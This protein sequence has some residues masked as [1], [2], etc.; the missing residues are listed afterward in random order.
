MKDGSAPW[1]LCG[2]RVRVPPW[3]LHA[4]PSSLGHER[5]GDWPIRSCPTW[6][7]EGRPR[8]HA[9]R[10]E[11]ESRC[12]VV[13]HT[14]ELDNDNGKV[15][16]VPIGRRLVGE[17]RNSMI[18][19]SDEGGDG[20]PEQALCPEPTRELVP[21]LPRR[22]RS[23]MYATPHRVT[24]E[25]SGLAG[26]ATRL[27]GHISE[28]EVGRLEL[29]GVGAGSSS[30]DGGDNITPPERRARTLG[31]LRRGGKDRHESSS[32]GSP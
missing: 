24:R 11:S 21:P 1:K 27:V 4:G 8:E 25:A 30:H 3:Q 18:S 7:V 19:R 12:S 6:G 29:G 13:I 20:R 28:S 23:G 10:S 5:S 31:T 32:G 26:V 2:E 16:P 22:S 9:G 17:V 15:E 14:V